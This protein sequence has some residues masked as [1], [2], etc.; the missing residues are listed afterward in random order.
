MTN[1]TISIINKANRTKDKYDILLIRMKDTKRSFAR[2]DIIFIHLDM[3]TAKSG[4][5]HML[6]NRVI[7]M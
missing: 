6:Q 5:I 4:M 2:L 7:T 3:T 1:K